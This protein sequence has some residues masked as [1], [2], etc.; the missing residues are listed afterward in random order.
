MIIDKNNKVIF[1]EIPKTGTSFVR[2][3]L[4][5]Y[6]CDDFI[7]SP[8][9]DHRHAGLEFTKRRYNLDIKEFDV[10]LFIR[11]PEDWF[12]TEFTEYI[13]NNLKPYLNGLGGDLQ[14]QFIAHRHQFFVDKD[15]F[16]LNVHLKMILTDENFLIP[17]KRC[18]D[19]GSIYKPYLDISE[20]L[21][22]SKIHVSKYEDF[23]D[24]ITKLFTA[25][26]KP[27]PSTKD[28]INKTLHKNPVPNRRNRSLINKIFDTDFKEFGYQKRTVMALNE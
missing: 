5:D 23:S 6:A 21:D 13:N 14:R 25:F 10:Y 4:Y 26:D 16:D 2:Q 22:P 17:Q 27:A 3:H 7:I 15:P 1:L 28:R 8:M 18:V 20:E 24:S 9:W 12:I 11:H 19:L